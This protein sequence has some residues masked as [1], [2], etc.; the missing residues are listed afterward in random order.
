MTTKS[1]ACDRDSVEQYF[2]WL[3]ELRAS[4]AVNMSGARPL[5]AEEFGLD[6]AL[7]TAVHAAWMQSYD[8]ESSAA[9]RAAKMFN[10]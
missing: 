5:L 3:D 4:G 9:D 2:E 1:D 6:R 7:S 8:G 10:S